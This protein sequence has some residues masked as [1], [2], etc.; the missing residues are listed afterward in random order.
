MWPMLRQGAVTLAL[1]VAV[2]VGIVAVPEYVGS[3]A[4][5]SLGWFQRAALIFSHVVRGELPEASAITRTTQLYR[6]LPQLLTQSTTLVIGAMCCALVVALPTGMATAM[7]PYNARRRAAARLLIAVSSM[8]AIVWATVLLLTSL[9]LEISLTTNARLA[10][11][12][13]LA[14]LVLGDRLVGDLT[15]RVESATKELLDEP[16]LRTVRASGFHVVRHVAQGLVPPVADA[17]ASRTLFLIG[18]AIVVERLFD[19]R[20][21][22]FRVF[23][24]LEANPIEREL[25]VVCAIGLV[26]LGLVVRS[27]ATGAAL[28]ADGRRR[29]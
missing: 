13:A 10:F 5:V 21:L 18:G 24:S 25:I 23:E 9:K 12:A 3:D 22:G 11:L 2:V 29:G 16:Y 26:V 14:T 7:A 15:A 8:P 6:D 27:V 17:V 19:I 20:G 4:P 28:L 1:A